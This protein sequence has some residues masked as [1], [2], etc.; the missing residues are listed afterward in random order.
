M[1]VIDRVFILL[2]HVNRGVS[3]AGGVSVDDETT[4]MV[5]AELITSMTS[6]FE[7]GSASGMKK[8]GL[9]MLGSSD[10]GVLLCVWIVV[11]QY[12][13]FRVSD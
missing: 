9:L 8:W 4:D 3:D 12:S 10:G 7:I 5:E 2:M 13:L 1:A 11:E 6:L